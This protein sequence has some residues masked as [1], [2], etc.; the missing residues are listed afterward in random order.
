[1][2]AVLSSQDACLKLIASSIIAQ[3]SALVAS[4]ELT[5]IPELFASCL[6]IVRL[7]AVNF[8][9]LLSRTATHSDGCVSIIVSLAVVATDLITR[10]GGIHNSHSSAAAVFQVDSIE[11]TTCLLLR[12]LEAFVLHMS[13]YLP[14]TST[15]TLIESIVRSCLECLCKGVQQVVSGTDKR[16]RWAPHVEVVRRSVCVQREV[17][18]LAVTEVMA[19]SKTGIL[20]A[21]VSLLKAAA[22]CLMASRG[23]VHGQ[24]DDVS[25]SREAARVLL[26]VGS[27][28]HPT[29]VPFVGTNAA[30][31]AAAQHKKKATGALTDA[32]GSG[33][34]G[35]AGA[36]GSLR[37]AIVSTTAAGNKRSLMMSSDSEEAENSTQ[38]AADSV[39]ALVKEPQAT[40]A[41]TP[42]KG[43][44]SNDTKPSTD[45][46]ED[47]TNS[48]KKA[49]VEA[50]ATNAL[51]SAKQQQQQQA[52]QRSSNVSNGH[53]NYNAMEDDDDDDLPEIR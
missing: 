1:L 12:T 13:C 32:M 43:A 39:F 35:V 44:D 41:P 36:I 6:R 25:I 11:H 2:E 29:A 30:M 53:S 50:T 22:Q 10:P 23:S 20:S 7:C 34:M 16:I 38:E 17:L 3:V 51:P 21:N 31:A 8:P 37:E 40:Q 27:L 49:K 19:P 24:D 28:L 9:Q 26:V 4:R 46:A 15:R 18:Q 52:P 45:Q 42:S 5:A 47:T 48:S 14:T 33:G